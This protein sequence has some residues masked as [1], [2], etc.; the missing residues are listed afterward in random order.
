[1]GT[2]QQRVSE[3]ERGRIEPSLY[4]LMRLLKIFSISF[5]E[6]TDGIEEK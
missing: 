4:N 2:T 1:M 3:W 5:E 6:L